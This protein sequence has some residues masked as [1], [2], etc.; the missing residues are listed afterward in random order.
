MNP[1][2]IWLTG[3]A[4]AASACLVSAQSNLGE[5]LDANAKQL[6]AED[7]KREVVQHMIVGPTPLGSPLE[8]MYAS[9]GAIAGRG[10]NPMDA[11]G[12][13]RGS[14][15]VS[16]DWK[17]G[18]NGRI[19]T[20]MRIGTT[21]LPARCQVWFRIGQDFF[22]SDSDTDRRAIVLRR[23]MK[24]YGAPAAV[25]DLGQLLDAGGK[26]VTQE[27]FRQELVQRV[28]TGPAATGGNLEIMYATNGLIAGV[29]ALPMAPQVNTVTAPV[30]GEWS[31]DNEGRVCSAVQIVPSSGP[32]TVLPRRCQSWY[33]LGS[34]YFLSDSDTDRRAKVFPRGLK[35]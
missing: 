10:D 18:E 29:T 8:I 28:V 30:R 34:S 3:V 11:P 21:L 16:G 19:C 17:V 9:N 22:V 23:S 25:T 1:L 14:I 27:E 4:L 20:S 7:F 6:S 35:Q 12:A 13:L 2:P 15:P 31:F 32:P 26:R 33:K 5:L 24:V